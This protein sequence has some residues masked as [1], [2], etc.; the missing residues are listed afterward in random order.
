NPDGTCPAGFDHR[1]VTLSYRVHFGI[2]DPCVGVTPC[3]P[4]DAPAENIQLSLSSGSYWTLHADF[5]N[6]WKQ[7]ALDGLVESC[8]NAHVDCGKSESAPTIPA[9]PM[10]A[11]TAGDGGVVPSSTPA[12]DGGAA[13]TGP[14]L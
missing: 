4:T 14:S 2:E 1:I 6:T 9:A 3:D 8:A 7:D 5:W 12:A 11:A 13:H 10:L